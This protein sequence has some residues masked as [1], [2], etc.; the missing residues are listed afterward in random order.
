M[1]SSREEKVAS[2]RGLCDEKMV[3]SGGSGELEKNKKS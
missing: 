1:K 2:R 3:K